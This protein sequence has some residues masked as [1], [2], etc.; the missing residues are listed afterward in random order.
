MEPK[1]GRLITAMVTPFTSKNEVDYKEAVRL[2]EFLVKNGSET[3]L[4]AGTTGECPTLTHEEEYELFKTMVQAFQGKAF[5]MAGAGSNSTATAVKSSQ[6]AETLGVDLLLQ[7][8]PYYNKPSQEGLY[9]HFKAIAENT[10]LP[11]IIYNI[12]GR[13]ARNMEPET[14]AR[15]SEIPNICGVKESAGSVEQMAAINKLTPDDF[16][17]YS[18]DDSMTLSFMEKG[19]CGVI[20][21]ASHCAGLKIKKM[22]ELYVL[23]KKKEAREVEAELEELFQVLFI[24]PNPIPVKAALT[25]MG[26]SVGM[27]RLPL[28][29]ATEEEQNAVR[30]CLERLKVI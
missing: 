27:P 21:V 18:G 14:M 12:P 4:L 7:V 20:S 3:L 6:N 9:Q 22:I 28:V 5:I 19:A 13:T 25:M 15:L 10:H 23:G 29:G 17:I 16:L 2:G 24:A 1:W 11:I 30:A 26:F 8:V